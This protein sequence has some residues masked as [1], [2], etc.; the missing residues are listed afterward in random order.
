MWVSIPLGGLTALFYLWL[1]RHLVLGHP[2]VAAMIRAR[3]ASVRLDSLLPVS[4][5]E[6]PPVL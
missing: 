1:V 3:L 2:P 5:V 4:A 6:H